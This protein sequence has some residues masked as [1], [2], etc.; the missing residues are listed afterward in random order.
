MQAKSKVYKAKKKD[1]SH[2]KR[3]GIGSGRGSTVPERKKDWE[4]SDD[5]EEGK[6]TIRTCVYVQ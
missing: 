4:M 3:R 6:R 1:S 2:A 5:E